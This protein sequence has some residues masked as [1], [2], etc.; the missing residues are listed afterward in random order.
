MSLLDEVRGGDARIVLLHGPVGIGKTALL[1]A[2]LAG[3]DA[4]DVTVRRA[5]C[6]PTDPP[7]GVASALVDGAHLL[8]IRGDPDD[9]QSTYRLLRGFSRL[10]TDL[11]AEPLIIALDDAQH[12]DK[13][14]RRWLEFLARRLGHDKIMIILAAGLEFDHPTGESAELL[15][16][17]P[18]QRIHLG[19]LAEA[20]VA[21][22]IAR[23]LGK[24]PAATFSSA[25]M[26][27][28]GGN[29]LLVT[30]L[31]TAMRQ[32]DVNPDDTGRDWTATVGAGIV[33]EPVAE[34][35]TAQSHEV[36]AT[37]IGMAILGTADRQL[38]RALTGASD[39]LMGDVLSLLRCLALY[40]P[41][42]ET[43]PDVLRLAV[44]AGLGVWEQ[45]HLRA[46][47][48]RLLND[49]G[50]PAEEVADQ[51]V[52]MSAQPEPWMLGVLW[53]AAR[54]AERRGN[55]DSAVR[56]LKRVLRE[57]P[58]DITARLA[59]ARTLSGTDPSAAMES[60]RETID[61]GP[62]DVRTRLSVALGYGLVALMA[63]KSPPAFGVLRDAVV[64][65]EQ[66]LGAVPGSDDRDLLLAGR[67]LL[68]LTGLD[69]AT[70]AANAIA[71][72]RDMEVPPGDTVAERNVLAMQAMAGALAGT[73]AGTVRE[74]A[75]RAVPAGNEPVGELSTLGVALSLMLTDEL[76][77]AVAALDRL[78][79]GNRQEASGWTL[80]LA[81]SI[82]AAARCVAGDF[83]SAY[84]DASAGVRIAASAAWDAPMVLPRVMLAKT[85]THCGEIDRAEA[86]LDT[87]RRPQL[88]EMVWQYPVYLMVR[89]AIQRG[90]ND[91]DGALRWWLLCRDH[92]ARSGIE[93][94]VFAPWWLEAAGTLADAGRAG[95]AMPFVE[96]GVQAARAWG[97]DRAMGL[98]RL[99]HGLVTPGRP[100]IA[101][102][103]HAVRTLAGSVAAEEHRR[104]LGAYGRALL[105][106]GDIR[107]A[108]V[109]LGQTVDLAEQ[110]GD[111]VLAEA[112]GRMLAGVR[113]RR[114]T[115]DRRPGLRALSAG[116]QRVVD[117]VSGG[118][119][120][121]EIA[122]ELF[123]SLRT[124]ESRLT[125][126]YR[127]LGA[128]GRAD[129][130]LLRHG[131][132]RPSDTGDQR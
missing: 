119:T 41:A 69:D 30:R 11:A 124:V 105:V 59:L 17:L 127:K 82:R 81:L 128:A 125:S 91:V 111:R 18:H 117:L 64:A 42:E 19:A 61:T 49:A 50:R 106:A 116:E 94:P 96:H 93:N 38:V 47:A 55:V 14:S 1:D 8:A 115:G 112:A 108:R 60:L 129:L 73:A 114:S 71:L 44:L 113:G 72:A 5:V 100:G 80:S 53:E 36:R 132:D 25:C 121:R 131:L 122:A 58:A 130:A 63:G 12:C 52:A 2:F 99:A 110:A 45:D 24:A 74:N 76:V 20:D 35:L 32:R 86:V 26:R 66:L 3:P 33:A 120:N 68:L 109:R 10:V 46:G 107:G 118:R 126:A 28:C 16:A 75:R 85:L 84:A 21:D 78:V 79:D 89:A 95:E 43:M 83:A 34:F 22:L 67:F 48:A 27:L 9:E 98:S 57:S 88:E 101:I 62:S 37:T 92:L 13:W 77:E 7:F 97:T 123:V 31:L 51:V 56:Y 29:P 54:C 104:A 4:I 6:R 102:L 103:E 65:I 70:T 87:A 40:D 90:R 23:T 15:P 39:R